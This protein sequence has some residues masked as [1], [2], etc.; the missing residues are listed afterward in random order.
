M[1]SLD[2]P[3]A[4][5]AEVAS[6]STHHRLMEQAPQEESGFPRNEVFKERLT[7]SQG[8]ATHRTFQVVLLCEAV[9]QDRDQAGLSLLH[10]GLQPA[11]TPAHFRYQ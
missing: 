1:I 9:Q 10:R 2:L 5:A 11:R 7:L 4:A 3:S 8:V 6:T